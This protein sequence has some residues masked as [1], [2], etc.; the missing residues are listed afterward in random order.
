MANDEHLIK[1]ILEQIQKGTGAKDTAND[2]EKLEQSAEAVEAV[3]RKVREEMAKLDGESR[4]SATGARAY[5]DHLSNI[6]KEGRAYLEQ[7]KAI[8]AA[9]TKVG[10]ANKDL[11]AGIYDTGQKMRQT[12]KAAS[13]LNEELRE[14]DDVAETAARSIDKISRELEDARRELYKMEIGTAQFNEQQKKVATLSRE[15]LVA[16]TAAA[17]G[18]ANAGNAIL[19]A[20]QGLEDMQYGIRGVQNNIPQLLLALG[21]GSGL[22]GIVSILVVGLGVLIPLFTE[23]G[24][25]AEKAAR[26]VEIASERKLAAARKERELS[27]DLEQQRALLDQ[28]AQVQIDTLLDEVKAYDALT[29]AIQRNYA[30]AQAVANEKLALDIALV[31]NDSSL[32]SLDKAVKINQLKAEATRQEEQRKLDALSAEAAALEEKINTAGN[33]LGSVIETTQTQQAQLNREIETGVRQVENLK[34]EYE[35]LT[36]FFQDVTIKNVDKNINSPFVP[37]NGGVTAPF[38]PDRKDF[39]DGLPGDK[40]FLDA[41][42]ND[43]LSGTPARADIESALRLYQQLEQ[44]TVTIN[45]LEGEVNDKK[46]DRTQLENRNGAFIDTLNTEIEGGQKRLEQLDQEIAGEKELIALREKRRQV[47]GAAG[48]ANAAATE[49]QKEV[50]ELGRD[51]DADLAASGAT[52][53]EIAAARAKYAEVSR[54]VAEALKDGVIDAGEFSKIATSLDEL[55]RVLTATADASNKNM[56]DLLAAARAQQKFQETMQLQLRQQQLSNVSP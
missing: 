2:L 45:Q 26:T 4:K 50:A 51:L 12:E 38:S 48:G 27:R 10:Y 6:A 25:A 33:D 28:Q 13:D 55:R 15:R 5:A 34:A 21:A 8:A 43:S 41:A 35:K 23:T 44:L 17:K 49:V 52:K 1:V 11:G 22:T 36:Q 37:G 53:E 18:T 7:A 29:A 56:A 46:K 16:E 3:V 30:Q 9:E 20:S 31:Q 42:K 39:G 47:E 19:F 14:Q 24:D 32:S 40:A 54:N